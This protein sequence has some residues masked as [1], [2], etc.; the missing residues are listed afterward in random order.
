MKKYLLLFVFFALALASCK[1]DTPF[2]P[3]KQAAADDASIQ[4]YIKAHSLSP[5][6]D[7]SGLYYQ[8]L[9]QGTGDYPNTNSLITA[10]YT[11]KLLNGTVFDSG[12][13]TAEPLKS[14]V[15]GWQVGL[16][17]INTGG[18]ILL[19]VPSALGYGNT[20]TNGIPANSVLI[21]TID[22]TGFSN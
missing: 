11:G 20:S 2:D 22:L 19:L 7:T 3:A 9:I 12:T 1:K 21:F 15:R 16:P 13:V 14:L 10:N 6:R 17:H 5:T 8:V 18:R 4:A